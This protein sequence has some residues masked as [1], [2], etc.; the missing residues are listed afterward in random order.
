[1]SESKIVYR[2]PMFEIL[3]LF[4]NV[5]PKT[6]LIWIDLNYLTC[7]FKTINKGY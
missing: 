7:F 5:V 4:Y 2:K 3:K 1:M 6:D